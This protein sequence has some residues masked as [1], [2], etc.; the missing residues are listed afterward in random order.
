M[1]CHGLV[2][3]RQEINLHLGKLFL[4]VVSLLHFNKRQYNL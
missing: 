4:P 2:D 3:I 1:Q